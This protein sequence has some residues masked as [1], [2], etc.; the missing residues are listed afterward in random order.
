MPLANWLAGDDNHAIRGTTENYI[1]CPLFVSGRGE[2]CLM[3]IE[4]DDTQE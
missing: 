3:E 2:V 4:S 1:P